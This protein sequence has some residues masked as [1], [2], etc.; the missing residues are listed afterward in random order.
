MDLLMLGG[1]NLMNKLFKTLALG[2]VMAV[3]AVIGAETT[4]A[5]NPCDDVDAKRAL[6]NKFIENY[7]KGEAQ[8]KVALEAG[9]EFVT[10]YGNCGGDAEQVTYL[11][12]TGLPYVESSLKAIEEKRAAA[13]EREKTLA[14]YNRFDTG[15]KAKNVADTLNAGKEILA[16]RP[17]FVDVYLVL[18]TMGYDESVKKNNVY[19]NEA[20]EYAK[21]A[22]QLIE[23]GKG[24]ES[25]NYGALSYAYKTDEYSTPEK[26]RS[27]A[28][29][30]MN[31]N[32]G[33][34][35]YFNQKNQKEALP[36][37]YKATQYDSKI[38]NL[39]APYR[40]IGDYY[41][42]EVARLDKERTA[43]LTANENQDTEETTKLFALEKAYADRAID[44]LA[45]AYKVAATTE[46]KEYRDNLYT[47]LKEVYNFR[48]NN[49]EGLDAYVASVMTKPMPNP[50]TEVTPVVEAETTTTT[51][52][53]SST[54]ST[55]P[56]TKAATTTS[57]TPAKTAVTSKSDATTPAGK[58]KTAP[59]R[60]RQR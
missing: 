21:K 22:I 41:T 52:T 7:D 37:L 33:S 17:D 45:R 57:T 32:I 51:T 23:S 53:T 25:K 36:Y 15:V 40:M 54:T 12:D 19:N 31:F 47:L 34:I 42:A 3:F 49:T 5:Q 35:M 30:W 26:A 28:L 46:T 6:Y 38:K 4:Y 55:T 50:T 29:G 1:K 2:I 59:Q 10:K 24:S 18:A 39:P 60:K 58:A 27:N 16:K 20:I 56:S 13:A 8:Q 14:L 44:A 11:K 48:H 43:K 9:K